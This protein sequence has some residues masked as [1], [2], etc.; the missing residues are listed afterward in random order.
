MARRGR[1]PWNRR[2]LPSGLPDWLQSLPVTEPANYGDTQARVK[3]KGGSLP[4]YGFRV[5][6]TPS[7]WPNSVRSSLTLK[8]RGGTTRPAMSVTGSERPYR[9]QTAT[10]LGA[11]G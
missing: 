5:G 3:E 8:G 9:E 4:A 6:P 1:A 11:P 10:L 7:G 2:I